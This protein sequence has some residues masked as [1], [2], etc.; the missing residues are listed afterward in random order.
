M[1]KNVLKQIQWLRKESKPF[2]TAIIYSTI[3]DLLSMGLSLAAIYFSKQTID[4]ATGNPNGNL[5]AHAAGMIACIVGSM[6][7]G[8]LNP[9][10]I[11]RNSMKFQMQLQMLLNGRMMAASWK[12]AQ[13]WH[14][15]DILNRLVKDCAEVVQL[16]VFTVPSLCVT[17]VELVAALVFLFILDSRIAWLILFSSP[18]LLLSKIYYKRMRKLSKEWKS[19]DS[20][21]TSVLQENTNARLLIASLGAENVRNA[22]LE[23]GLQNRLHT[24]MQQLKIGIYSKT[25][26]QSVFHTG[27]FLAF[28]LG[29]Y[30][31]SKDLITFGTMVAFIQLVG[32]IQ[33][34][35]LQ[36]IGFVPGLI[37]V[38]ASVERIMELEEC[39]SS[40][41]RN[42]NI[43]RQAEY[44]K[45]EDLHFGYSD[46]EI[47]NGMSF[48]VKAGEPL[49]IMGHTGVGKTTL[50]RL[51]AS[52][53]EP[54]QGNILLKGDGKDWDT[55]ELERTNF[56]YVPQGNSLF[57]GTIRDNLR[58]VNR[59]A[60]DE[61]LKEA[62]GTACADFVWDLAQGLDTEI[63][64]NGLG[65]SEG[66]AQRL[67]VARAMLLPG[68]V[69]I[70]DEVTAALDAGTA[71]QLITNLLEKGKDKILL[72]VT[73]DAALRDRCVR[74][75]QCDAS[76]SGDC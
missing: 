46:G 41:K 61:Q 65:L 17:L 64:E 4:I 30:Y 19:N 14:T 71:Q 42:R 36:F 47:I 7:A 18:L 1:I 12:S 35:I 15:G 53:L 24:G 32:R 69:W 49:A 21:V 20:L 45:V 59:E 68:S 34:P 38:R 63:G 3:I 70:F 31:L 58:M 5:W 48:T 40:R 57:S 25:I 2:H 67:A 6:I 72:F 55:A 54:N 51:I 44:L 29:I 60:S 56:V 22:L 66:Q 43:I 37:R 9:W 62:L 23:E 33:G 28:L 26:L 75:I 52:I 74:T 8:M 73:H 16:V 76:V 13:Q 27:Y 10:M 39:P 11:E 50:I